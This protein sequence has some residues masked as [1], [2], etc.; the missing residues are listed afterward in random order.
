[1]EV[2]LFDPRARKSGT[3]GAA[4]ITDQI[5][6]GY[7]KDVGPS[8]VYGF[9]VHGPRAGRVIVHP[10]KLVLDP[11]ARGHTGEL[12]WDPAASAPRSAP[13]TMT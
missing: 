8:S 1:V 7:I 6:H 3:A 12:K 4:R 13:Q 10:N 9:R 2:C 11:Y 5:W